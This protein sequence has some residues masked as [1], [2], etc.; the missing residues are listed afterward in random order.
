MTQRCS[1][2]SAAMPLIAASTWSHTSWAR[3]IS[4]ISGV[5][6]NAIDDVVPCVAQT[7]NG[8]S[9]AA[10]SASIASAS[11]A[12]TI[13]NDASWATVRM[14]SVPMPAMRRPFSMLECA[15]EVAYAT[16]LDVSPSAL[17]RPPVARQRADRIATSV[18]SLA[19][20]WITPPPASVGRPEPLGERQQLLHPV[21]HQRLDLGACRRRDP[22][23]ALDPEPGRGQLAE[24][25]GVRDVGRE[26][27]EELRV[28]PMRQTG[29]DDRP[30]V[31]EHRRERLRRG[32]WV[33]RQ[34]GADLARLHRRRNRSLLDVLEVLGDEVDQRVAVRAEL[35]G[36]HGR[37]R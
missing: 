5:G 8:T 13:A 9:P 26:V 27:G 2:A 29:D 10:S 33:L 15:C 14:R 16:S 24:D 3:Q 25:R 18:A 21:E 20:P 6:S 11:A 22:A 4:P 31:V 1:G 17:T 37:R 19:E 12:G 35:L 34:S 7:K 36:R 28:L 30:Q 32:W 23:H